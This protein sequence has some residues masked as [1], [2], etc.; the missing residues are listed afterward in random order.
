M[1]FLFR[2]WCIS[3]QLWWG[4][5]IPAWLASH[6]AS[7]RHQWVAAA[8]QDAALAKAA[9]KLG[10]RECFVNWKFFKYKTERIG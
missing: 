8:T 2:D 4:H 6:R 1:V 7:G 10:K 9:A 3:R 5:R